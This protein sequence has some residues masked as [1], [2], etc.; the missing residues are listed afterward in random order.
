M[1][2]LSVPH[3]SCDSSVLG[4]AGSTEGQK[5]RVEAASG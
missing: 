2:I 3:R 5:G 1:F 4:E